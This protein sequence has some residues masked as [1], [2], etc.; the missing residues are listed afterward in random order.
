[1]LIKLIGSAMVIFASAVGGLYFGYRQYYRKSDLSA[2]LTAMEI[3]ENEINNF[4]SLIEAFYKISKRLS[5]NPVASV[6]EDTVKEL[7]KK[8]GDEFEDIWKSKLLNFK[9]ILYLNEEDYDKILSFGAIMKNADRDLEI[10]NINILKK[11]LRDKADEINE[12]YTK[13]RKI[14]QSI[15]FLGGLMIAITLF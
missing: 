14:Y 8:N 15:G 12:Q 11:Y 4:S 5:G 7:E 6:F 10:R 1:M 13:N 3:L 9:N 2:F